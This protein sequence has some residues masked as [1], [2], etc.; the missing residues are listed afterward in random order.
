MTI[1]PK[2]SSNGVSEVRLPVI[3]KGIIRVTGSPENPVGIDD[4]ALQKTIEYTGDP[5]NIPVN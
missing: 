4:R 5:V 3:D 1:K 2:N